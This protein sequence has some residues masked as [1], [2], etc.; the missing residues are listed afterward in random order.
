[1]IGVIRALRGS[2]RGPFYRLVRLV[3][4][5]LVLRGRRE[6][7]KEVYELGVEARAHR[8]VSDEFAAGLLDR[9]DISCEGA[10]RG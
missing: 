2:V 3:V 5:L 10:P 1:M 6:R 9:F 7:S 4:D 8:R